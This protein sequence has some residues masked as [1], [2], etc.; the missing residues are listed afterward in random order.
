MEYREV[1]ERERDCTETSGVLTPGT[2]GMYT[3]LRRS[4]E[5]WKEERPSCT[6]VMRRVRRISLEE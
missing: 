4:Q 3:H 2:V 5:R 1:Q 6:A